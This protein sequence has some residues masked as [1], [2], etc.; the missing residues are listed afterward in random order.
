MVDAETLRRHCS[1]DAPG[2][3]VHPTAVANALKF[4]KLG[5]G[6]VET[7]ASESMMPAR[8]GAD[9]DEFRRAIASE[10]DP[11]PADWPCQLKRQAHA[12]ECVERNC[13]HHDCNLTF[14]S[15]KLGNVIL[16]P[17]ERQFL[18]E[19]AKVVT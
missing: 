8:N 11:D 19:E 7:C 12:L 3:S 5:L 10:T 6:E 14:V 2:L 15:S 4:A 9:S 17:G 1:R 18:I 16:H 13:T